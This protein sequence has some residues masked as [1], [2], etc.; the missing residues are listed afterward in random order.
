[1]S[2]RSDY[3]MKKITSA[4]LST[5]SKYFKTVADSMNKLR[6]MRR[7]CILLTVC[8]Y[9]LSIYLSSL[10]VN[11]SIYANHIRVY[12]TRQGFICVVIMYMICA[13]S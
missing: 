7:F 5:N 2:Y 12:G 10:Y 11:K 1:M 9:F 4:N 13:F 6:I 3:Q 8:I